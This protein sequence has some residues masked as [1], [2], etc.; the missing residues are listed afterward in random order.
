VTTEIS[1]TPGPRIVSV[2]R[3]TDIPAFYAPWFMN[4]VRA[5]FA[6]VPNPFNTRQVTTV[7][8]RPE[9]VTCLVFW[10]RNPAPLLPFLGEFDKRGFRF[11]FHVTLTGLPYGLEPGV[12]PEEESVAVFHR[13]SDRI[14][15]DKIVWR[16]DPLF[17]PP[18]IPTQETLENFGRLAA[19]LEGVVG[20]VMVSFV[21]PYRQ[22][23]S[24]LRRAG[25][26]H[27]LPDLAKLPA[28]DA[29]D[30]IR[31][32]VKP[33]AKIARSHRLRLFSCASPHDLSS[34]GVPPGRCIDGDLI[35]D[36][37][38]LE[39]PAKKDPGQRSACR[40]LP[41]VDI[42]MYGACRH[43]CRYCYAGGGDALARGMVHEESAPEL[44]QKKGC[45]FG[46]LGV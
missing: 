15:P 6:R 31:P 41:S 11:Y 17:L 16:F 34:L 24:R 29:L 35:R 2:S 30:H 37:F 8:L 38:G 1:R 14:G 23:V 5:G 36:L 42:G 28:R 18:V 22:A 33:L 27:D 26:P 4:R 20:R 45:G 9:D 44:L 3:R 40:C 7:S 12:S 10:T 19:R 43:G 25:L 21:Q 39:I 32:L 13:L 46:C